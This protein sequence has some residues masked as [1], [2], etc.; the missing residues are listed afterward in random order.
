M[1]AYHFLKSDMTTGS[2]RVRKPWVVGQT[3]RHGGPVELCYSG[4][5]SSPTPADALDYAPGPILCVV[6]VSK[7]V[8]ADDDK[9]VSRRRTLL[10]AV[11]A[12]DA[13]HRVACDIAEDVLPIY[14]RT[15][16]DDKRPRQAIEAKRQWL[17]GEMSTA[18]LKVAQTAA[19]DAAW[20]AARAAAWDAVR[21]ADAAAWAAARDAVRAADAAAWAAARAAARDAALKKYDGWINTA[22]LACLAEAEGMAA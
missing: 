4:F 13:I 17:A 8:E 12:T 10:Q 16:P 15:H 9:Q 11:D 5:H 7:P 21:A 14:E 22:L 20:A 19:G 6:D 1:K 3:R 18:D 2:G